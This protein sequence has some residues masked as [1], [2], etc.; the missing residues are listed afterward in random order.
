MKKVL[1]VLL[2]LVLFCPVLSCALADDDGAIEFDLTLSGFFDDKTTSDIYGSA[3]MRAMFAFSLLFDAYNDEATGMGEADVNMAEMLLNDDVYVGRQATGLLLLCGYHDDN[4]VYVITYST[5]TD[6]ANLIKTESTFGSL[7][8]STLF[9]N[10]DLV[11]SYYTVS[12]SDM[13][14][15]LE[16]IV[17]ALQ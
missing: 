13:L 6:S 11:S 3:A 8:L 17:N 4:Y 16:V 12:S 15:V 14:T 7:L 2:A 5:I 10:K 1:S 9:S